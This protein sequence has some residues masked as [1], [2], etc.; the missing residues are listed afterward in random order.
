MS[1]KISELPLYVGPSQPSG[2]LPIS[3]NG[4]TYA[5]DP[6]NLLVVVPDR[7][8]ELIN[9]G[10]TGD[11]PFVED[12]INSGIYG[13]QSGAWVLLTGEPQTFVAIATG[14]NQTFTLPAGFIAGSVL[15][16]RGE[17]Y[18]GSEWTQSGTT[19]TIIVS[20]TTGNTIYVKP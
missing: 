9:D 16:S 1:K 18:K 10:A 14:T 12:V 5:I 19:L 8:S 11:S 2:L 6:V 4:V 7:T 17:L 15:K 13:R 20:V 3:I